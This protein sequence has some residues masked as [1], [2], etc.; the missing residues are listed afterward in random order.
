MTLNAGTKL[1]HYEIVSPLGAGGMGEVYRARD[2]KLG[3]DVALKVLPE[4]VARDAERMARFQREAQVLA[5]LNH[6]NIATIHGLEESGG[7]R[8]LVM[9]LVEGATLADRLVGAGLAPAQGRP[10]GSPLP[11][12]EA[13]PVAKQISEA[14]EYAH[15]RGIIHRDL[16]PANIKITPEGNVKIL[17][18]GLAKA[19][20]ITAA[21]SSGSGSALQNSPTLTA[22]ATQAG[23][24]LGTAA[25]MSPEQ[26]KGKN[27][28]RRS[29]IWSFGCV[30]YEMLSGRRAFEGE[31]AT[32]TLAGVLR[33]DPDW[34]ALPA[35]TPTSLQKL[36]RRCLAKDTK[37]RLQAIGEAR[38]AIEETIS[39]VGADGV[40]PGDA[41]A[42]SMGRS[43]G[44]R[45]SPLTLL[46]V[47]GLALALGLAAGWWRKAPQTPAEPEWS[48]Q[49]LGGPLFALGPRISPDGHTL[50]FQGTVDR[51]T[52]VAVMDTE[53]GD[54]TV[55]TKNR[56]RGFVTELNWSP[57]GSEIFFDRE[58]S[59]PQGVY[60]VSRFGGEEH[61]VLKDAKGPE[62]LPDGS[63][64]VTRLNSDRKFQLYRYWP[65]NER[66]EA[67]DA[68]P[69]GEDLCPAVRAFRDGKDAVFIGRTSAQDSKDTSVHLYVINLAS[70]KSRRLAPQ[71]DFNVPAGLP[72]FPLGIANDDGAVLVDHVTGNLH[73]IISIPRDGTGPSQNL[74]TLTLPPLFIDVGK[75][76]DVY[77]DQLERPFEILRFPASGGLP[78]S[79][80]G[81]VS[82][83]VSLQSPF[84]LPDGRAT[85]D[86]L[87]AGR[88]KLLAINS[89]SELVPF[90]QTKEDASFPACMV[91]KSEIAFMLGSFGHAVVAL[92]SVADGQV[93]RR[94]TE[95]PAGDISA[96][97]G[98]LDG[99]TL[100]YVASGTVWAI[101]TSGG[102]PRR[103]AA[104][105]S[106][107]V[108]PNGKDLI[109]D[110]RDREG[111]RLVRIPI[112]GGAGVSIPI[113]GALRLAPIN[114]TSN[115]MGKDGRVLFTAASPDS[116]FYG[117]GI[118]DPQSGKV[119]MIP[120][121]FAGDVFAPSWL[122]DGRIISAG[123]PTKASLWR[124][125]PVMH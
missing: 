117:A 100:F 90:I 39:G 10:Q 18:F 4:A 116:W 76:G 21:S 79:L 64:L 55:L 53:S 103:V 52:Q 86:L 92:A 60:T 73:R 57:D 123:L 32:E 48:G 23:V 85:L 40:R 105:E 26:A 94:F 81:S 111:I 30:L 43:Q 109:V 46:L 83:G 29:D 77:L 110:V 112:S 69:Y 97:A 93:S 99:K 44:E 7:V 122:A 16:K 106:I 6:P 80:A 61:L 102:Q 15:E 89:S 70:G 31:T 82:S 12:D 74:F 124:F 96:L 27:V 121:S 50:A 47:A 119:S 115:A 45:R 49:I 54:W 38:I 78:E 56:S 98:S 25:Y 72:I 13:L 1:G 88:H 104:G 9:E 120:L 84:Q 125:R 114:L 108:D 71:V 34:N 22:A 11:I 24:V 58:F 95:I 67:L 35:D 36:L 66:L 41:G 101:P 65:E 3:R 59:V 118:L 91:G 87:V 113:Q 5:S 107:T 17:D 19:L 75:N 14:L 42:E 20:D 37:Q 68:L 33:A 2:L 51:L 28:D 63:L 8:A 62:V